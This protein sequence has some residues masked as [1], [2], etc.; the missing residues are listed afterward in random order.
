MWI[1]YNVA[2]NNPPPQKKSVPPF[3]TIGKWKTRIRVSPSTK[4]TNRSIFCICKVGRDDWIARLVSTSLASRDSPF[5]Y[6]LLLP[7]NRRLSLLVS[8]F[9]SV[10]VSAATLIQIRQLRGAKQ[11][12]N[13][14]VASRTNRWNPRYSRPCLWLIAFQSDERW[15]TRPPFAGDS[16]T[17][18][19]R[20]REKERE[21]RIGSASSLAD[22][23][24]DFSSPFLFFL[25]FLRGIA[26]PTG[27]F[28]VWLWIGN[29]IVG[30]RI[31]SFTGVSSP[32]FLIRFSFG[33]S[34]CFVTVI[35]EN[36]NAWLTE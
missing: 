31:L 17:L 20:E 11:P 24:W 25:S 29:L 15:N 16:F 19:E 13:T 22:S 26:V 23:D 28:V 36:C 32:A 33:C 30:L 14:A 27:C 2:P 4:S 1:I 10:A 5:T 8:F 9:L 34:V 18:Q 7:R 6:F 12:R 35:R 3:A 21:C